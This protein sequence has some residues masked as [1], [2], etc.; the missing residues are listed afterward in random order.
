MSFLQRL[1]NSIDHRI[2]YR[3][4][5]P[6]LEKLEIQYGYLLVP[7][8]NIINQ[9][10]LP[11]IALV[12]QDVYQDL[13]CCPPN[14]KSK[15][16][17]LSSF[18]RSGFVALFTKLNADFWIIK[19]EK[20]PECNIWKQKC[21][22]CKQEPV[23][24]YESLK[25][26]HNLYSKSASE[27]DWNNYD[28]VISLDISIPARITKKYPQVV[29]CYCIGEPCMSS[30]QLSKINPIEG[31]DLFFNQQFRHFSKVQKMSDHEVEF[32]YYL[33]YYG[34]FKNI[35]DEEILDSKK[36]GIF[37]EFNWR[38]VL[39]DKQREMLAKFG[40]LRC[41]KGIQ[42]ILTDLAKS[43]YFIIGEGTRGLW[44]N[45]MIEAIA[46][47]CLLIGN[48]LYVKHKSLFTPQTI[49][50]SF[51]ELITKLEFFE[52]HEDI[53]QRELHRQ[54]KLLNYICFNRPLQDLFTKARKVL[55]QR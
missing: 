27:I 3:T 5:K 18:Q 53:Y 55:K 54:R 12:K 52:N 26:K 49:V 22:D 2:R 21:Y 6:I 46:S 35:L 8:I 51:D 45:G 9:E 34:C 41:P 37:L 4:L 20:D 1:S 36:E 13:Y 38:N 48:P 10:N 11:R 31:Y 43:K 44:G 7:E 33:Q 15:N 28:I 32:P 16:L 19:T 17:I 14:S 24:F 25:E 47:G 29:W 50:Y 42:N 39:T 23:E 30:Y 40:D